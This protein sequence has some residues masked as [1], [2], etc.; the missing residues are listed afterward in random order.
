MPD[1]KPW[2]NVC[3][4]EQPGVWITALWAAGRG[5]WSSE[6]TEKTASKK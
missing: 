1:Y 2:K 6:K 3:R 5:S 4:S